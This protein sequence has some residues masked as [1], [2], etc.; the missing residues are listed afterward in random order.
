MGINI[1]YMG[2]KRSL[3]PAVCEVISRAQSGVLLDAFSGMCSIG[4]AV[5]TARQIWNN[6]VLVFASQV[7]KALFVSR[8]LPLSPLSCGDIHFDHYR[9]QRD[10]LS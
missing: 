5:G 3:A 6:D 1:T 2:T 4:E 10:R 8:D 9:A 7:A